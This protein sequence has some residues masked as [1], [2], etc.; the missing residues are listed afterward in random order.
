MLRKRKIV[1]KKERETEEILILK[2]TRVYN[3]C[4]SGKR[5]LKRT[6]PVVFPFFL[7]YLLENRF[8]TKQRD[9][10][11]C[12]CKFICLFVYEK[13]C[14]INF[15]L[16]NLKEIDSFC[17][18]FKDLTANLKVLREILRFCNKFEVLRANLRY[19]GQI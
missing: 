15:I 5:H 4:T 1:K 11:F 14:E 16:A 19:L 8:G 17:Y 2:W 13:N 7:L 12:F 6:F 10:V 18:Q 9:W 3:I